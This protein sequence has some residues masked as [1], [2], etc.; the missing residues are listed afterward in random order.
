VAEDKDRVEGDRSDVEQTDWR[1][2]ID[3]LSPSKRALLEVA[4]AKRS[5][6]LEFLSRTLEGA[7]GS[8]TPEKLSALGRLMVAATEDDDDDDALAGLIQR[9]AGT[10]GRAKVF[11]VHPLGGQVACYSELGSQLGGSFQVYGIQSVG[12]TGGNVPASSIEELARGYAETVRKTQQHGPYR[13]V[14]WSFGALVAFEMARLLASDVA[15]LILVD[16]TEL[17]VHPTLSPVEIEFYDF[18]AFMQDLSA[19][20]GKELEINFDP[21][22]QSEE[23]RLS[24]AFQYAV[25]RDVVPW[26]LQFDAFRQRFAIFRAN[27]AALRAYRPLSAPVKALVVLSEQ[28]SDSEEWERLATGGTTFLRLPGDHYSM[29]RE[30]AEVRTLASRV[31]P[32]L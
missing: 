15:A 12:L 25:D 5:G 29:M 9:I 28:R 24:G 8:I 23:A 27:C 18:L 20:A 14:G 11:C 19:L 1:Q 2:L 21:S 22:G 3:A 30:P 31:A 7:E 13:L 17:G 16:P 10:E 4:L 32:Y 6:A 26:T